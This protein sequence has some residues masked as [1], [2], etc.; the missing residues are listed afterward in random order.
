MAGNQ[1]RS[2][3]SRAAPAAAEV[4]SPLGG[5]KASDGPSAVAAPRKQEEASTVEM[6]FDEL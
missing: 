2:D 1:I 5:P 6:C 4:V 3:Q